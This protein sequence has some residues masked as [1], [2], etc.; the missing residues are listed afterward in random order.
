VALAF[1]K[2]KAAPYFFDIPP[3]NL[4][5]Q[6]PTAIGL[7]F[8]I[9]PATEYLKVVIPAPAP[10][11]GIN[12]SRNPGGHWMPDQV[13]HDGVSLFNCRVNNICDHYWSNQ[14]KGDSHDIRE[15]ERK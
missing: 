12:C 14:L 4:Y 7:T 15:W 1:P 11:A 8:F 10:W 2:S 6:Q 9:T 5:I 13:R 3:I